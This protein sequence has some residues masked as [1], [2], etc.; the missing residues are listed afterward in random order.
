MLEDLLV[1]AFK[2]AVGKVNEESSQRMAAVT[3]GMP[4]PPG[5]KLP[6]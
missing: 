2:D 4:L 3:A 1:V 5:L 6:F